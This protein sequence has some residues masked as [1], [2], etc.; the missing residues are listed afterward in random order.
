MA[1]H[2]TPAATKLGVHEAATA[3]G[4]AEMMF[5]L[6]GQGPALARDL[7]AGELVETLV[8]ET[9]DVVSSFDWNPSG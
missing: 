4:D 1:W 8:A 5:L 7:P 2:E 9:E 3:T 6:A